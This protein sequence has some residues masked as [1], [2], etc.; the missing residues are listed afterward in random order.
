MFSSLLETAN[1]SFDDAVGEGA[2]RISTAAFQA[3]GGEGIP[4]TRA[5]LVATSSQLSFTLRYN[6]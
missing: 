1:T 2:S 3:A 4:V 6:L 5:P